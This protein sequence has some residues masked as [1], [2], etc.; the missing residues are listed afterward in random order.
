MAAPTTAR[1]PPGLGALAGLVPAADLPLLAGFRDWLRNGTDHHSPDTVR[2]YVAHL[3]TFFRLVPGAGSLPVAE[4]VSKPNIAMAIAGIPFERTSTRRNTFF[5]AKA[6]ARYL[7]DLDLI[8]ERTAEAIQ[9]MRI[10]RGA[11][12]TRAHLTREQ[13]E[14]VLRL[15]LVRGK[16]DAGERLAN[17]AVARRLICDRTALDLR[18]QIQSRRRR[19]WVNSAQLP[20][21]V[22][23][24]FPVNVQVKFYKVIVDVQDLHTDDDVM[25]SHIY[26]LMG[27][28]DALEEGV[29][30]VRQAHGGSA[31]DPIEVARPKSARGATNHNAFVEGAQEAYRLARAQARIGTGVTNVRFQDCTFG[32][33]H[34]ISFEA[35]L[36]AGAW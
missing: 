16:Y 28:E 21:R 18:S 12:P 11:R 9:A 15:A 23:E 13:V 35:E 33:D 8:D 17:L 5:A 30:Y 22:S 19:H 20:A 34:Q 31:E 25:E 6:L 3:V 27:P 32:V 1:N 7:A 10:K 36:S 29:V 24:E 2:T 4:A 26:F 14:E